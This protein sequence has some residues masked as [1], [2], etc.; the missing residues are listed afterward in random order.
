MS[1]QLLNLEALLH[2]NEDLLHIVRELNEKGLTVEFVKNRMTFRPDKKD[3]TQSLMLSMLAAFATFERDLIR[4]RQAEGIAI[5][6]TK[7]YT[8]ADSHAS[9]RRKPQTSVSGQH[10]GP[11]R[12]T[13]RGTTASA[14]RPSTT[15]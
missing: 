5:A 9:L 10:K 15:T 6:K 3:S 14:G 13:S 1:N 8:R 11:R 12:W 7:G 4:E 2:T